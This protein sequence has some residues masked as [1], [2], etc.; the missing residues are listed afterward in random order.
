MPSRSRQIKIE[1]RCATAPRAPSASALSGSM[2]SARLAASRANT[3]AVSTSWKPKS[4]DHSVCESQCCPHH[5]GLRVDCRSLL[6][7][8]E[9]LR[10]CF[11]SALSPHHGWPEATRHKLPGLMVPSTLGTSPNNLIFS[12]SR[13]HRCSYFVL[14][15]A[16]MFSSLRS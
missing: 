10:E 7:Q 2:L 1:P 14:N 9:G 13:Y 3:A 6:R 12:Q 16:K 15:L 11:W 5:G 8:F 4:H